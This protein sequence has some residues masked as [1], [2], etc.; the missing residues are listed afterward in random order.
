[1]QPRPKHRTQ[2]HTI[3]PGKG[4]IVALALLILVEVMFHQDWVLYRLRSVFAAGR[5]FDKVLFVES[6]RPQLL[7]VGNSRVDNGFDPETILETMGHVAPQSAFN[8]GLPGADA[9]IVFGIFLRLDSK[10]A[11]GN[12]GV[13]RV[14]IGLD[15]AFVQKVDTLGQEVF[16]ADRASMWG[17][18]EYL[19]WLRSFLRLYGYCDNLRQMREPATF[20]RFI[21]ALRR[22]TEP[23]GGGASEHSGY[24]AGFGGLQD[25]ADAQRQDAGSINPPYSGNVINLWRIIDLLQ[26]RGVR[27]EVVFPPLLNRN[28]LYMQPTN[29]AALPYKAILKDLQKRQIPVHILDREIPRNPLEFVNVGHL[30]DKGAQHYSILLGQSLSR[31]P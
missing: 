9:R 14:V 10:R 13:Q 24:R 8:L 15:E 21:E 2:N 31:T 30:N 26:D 29:P 18:G 23:V 4:I 22:D 16:F 17:D 19:D 20:F 12:A 6:H 11:L 28:V 27:V 7:I 25:T 3:I 5:A 1:M